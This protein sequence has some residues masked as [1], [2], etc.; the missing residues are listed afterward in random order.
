VK[1]LAAIIPTLGRQDEVRNLLGM[2]AVQTRV[3][4]EVIIADQNEP[5]LPIAEWQRSLVP[6]LN[7]NHLRSPKKGW[8]HNVNL[9]IRAAQSEVVLIL[10][11]DII[12]DPKLVETHLSAYTSEAFAAGV[13]SVAGRVEQPSGDVDPA[14]IRK[15][16]YYNRWTG[17]FAANFNAIERQFVQM[18]PGGNVSFLRKV[19]LE[20]G[21]F[22]E[23]FDVGNG[24]FVETDGCLSVTERGYKMLF[25]PLA[26][27]KH[28]QSPRGGWR[29]SDKALHTY[30]FVR[31][32]FCMVRKHSPLLG[33]PVFALRMTAYV[34]AKSL[35]NLSPRIFGLGLKGL[36]D[37]WNT[38]EAKKAK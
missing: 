17:A 5:A 3:P 9:A 19:L 30:Y 10:D 31:N 16:G 33:Q 32:G 28:L 21:G 35:Y 24:N 38:R 22:D 20:V 13:V 37:G 1:T 8:A 4:D 29:M 12:A 6:K 36:W 2:L 11:D 26:S 18:A 34:A 23:N 7:V 25:E 14:Q 15:V 27:V